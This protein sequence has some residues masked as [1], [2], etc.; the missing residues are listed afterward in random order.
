[1]QVDPHQ[2]VVGHGEGEGAHQREGRVVGEGPE[3][4]AVEHGEVHRGEQ[5]VDAQVAD[6]AVVEVGG[7][8]GRV[9]TVGGVAAPLQGRL[10]G[11]A[12]AGGGEGVVD[13]RVGEQVG[14]RIAAAV[15]V[16]GVGVEVAGEDERGVVQASLDAAVVALPAVGTGG[17]VVRPEGDLV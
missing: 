10:L 16:E 1:L 8:V 13:P 17:E 9:A 4:A 5:V 14:D 3:H 7:V 6:A 12:F 2:A 15:A 11:P